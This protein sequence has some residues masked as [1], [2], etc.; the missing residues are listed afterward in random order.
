MGWGWGGG[1][2]R[3]WSLKNKDNEAGMLEVREDTEGSALFCPYYFFVFVFLAQGYEFIY[4]KYALRQL[5]IEGTMRVFLTAGTHRKGVVLS[6][7][8]RE[9]NPTAMAA[10][11]DKTALYPPVRGLAICSWSID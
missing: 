10:E 6:V 2:G 4:R 7:E 3:W 1:Y 9:H 5:V 8:K 11:G